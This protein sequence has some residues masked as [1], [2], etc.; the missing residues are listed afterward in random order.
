MAESR[1]ELFIE[2][3]TGTAF[4]L[5]CSPLETIVSIKA[6]IQYSEGIPVSQ[7]HLIWKSQ[8]LNDD[9]CLQDYSIN[10]GATLKLVLGMRGGPINTRQVS[11]TRKL[12]DLAEYVERSSETAGS[13][14]RPLTVLVF[15]DGDKVHMYTLMERGDCTVS[16]P[17]SGTISETSSVASIKNV[18]DLDQEVAKENEVTR[19]KVAQLQEQLRAL[20]INK[21]KK[22]PSAAAQQAQ[23]E[24]FHLPPLQR[25]DQP[26]QPKQYSHNNHAQPKTGKARKD[27]PTSSKSKVPPERKEACTSTG[28]QVHPSSQSHRTTTT[29][30]DYISSNISSFSLDS[31]ESSRS[32]FLPYLSAAQ[33]ATG[34]K[35][36][37]SH[38]VAVNRGLGSIVKYDPSRM[39]RCP[40]TSQALSTRRFVDLEDWL[41]NRPKTSPE[42]STKGDKTKDRTKKRIRH[43]AQNPLSLSEGNS[44]LLMRMLQHDVSFDPPI[45]TAASESKGSSTSALGTLVAGDVKTLKSFSLQDSDIPS[46]MQ[47]TKAILNPNEDVLRPYSAKKLPLIKAKKKSYKRCSLCSKKTGLATSFTCRCGKNFCASHRY[48]ELHH[49]SY[50]YKTEGRRLL[51]MN[52]PVVTASK[53]PKI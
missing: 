19:E 23:R 38:A 28:S 13:G 37:G 46:N 32:T 34:Q 20:N 41:Q 45:S 16:S 29:T 12:R 30:L 7:Q 18:E 4:E 3:L 26:V 44:S 14:G 52:N 24:E 40:G 9:L 10:D 53:L 22:L 33:G 6:K 36:E 8:E 49:C 39:K 21:H 51:Q 2:T 25:M 50:D 11:D 27:H 31:S 1:M 42:K 15:H 47:S 5:S 35:G 43:G 17:L 48:A